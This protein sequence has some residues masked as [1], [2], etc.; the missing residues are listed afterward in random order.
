MTCISSDPSKGI[1]KLSIGEWPRKESKQQLYRSPQQ[2][3]NIQG[4]ELIWST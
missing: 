1:A 3:Q 4:N 2:T